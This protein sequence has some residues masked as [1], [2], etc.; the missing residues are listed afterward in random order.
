MEERG[1]D[2]LGFDSCTTKRST[3]DVG[4]HRLPKTDVTVC[5]ARTM[6]LFNGHEGRGQNLQ[7]SQVMVISQYD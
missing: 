2:K 3:T 1:G 7:S 5:V 6:R 4:S